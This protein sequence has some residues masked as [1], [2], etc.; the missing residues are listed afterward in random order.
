MIRLALTSHAVAK[1]RSHLFQVC[2]A[3]VHLGKPG[4]VLAVVL[5][6]YAGMVLAVDHLP[7]PAPALYGLAALFLTAFGAA[8]FNSLMERHRDRSMQRLAQR[9][10]ALQLLGVPT[11]ATVAGGAICAG[12]ATA[13]QTLDPQ[14][15]VLILLALFSY[16]VIYTRILKPAS[17]WAAVLGGLPGALPVLVGSAAISPDFSSS[18][19]WLFLVLLFWQPPHFWLLALDHLSDYR[20][21]GIPVLP[22]IANPAV[23][24]RAILIGIGCLIP[25]SLCLCWF[26]T[27]SLYYALGAALLGSWFLIATRASLHGKHPR[28]AF[29]LSILYLVCLLTLIIIDRAFP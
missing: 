5:S 10:A 26:G 3:L 29:V 1:E 25:S 6:G 13:W 19:Y 27:C 22:L 14:V 4:I 2:R 15:T 18:V 21:A 17:P 16:V 23:T 9:N 12:L 11:I 8:L 7:D 20:L 24:R 28:P